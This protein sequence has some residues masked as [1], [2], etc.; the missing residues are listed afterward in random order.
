MIAKKR[1]IPLKIL[2]LTALLRRLPKNH[3]KRPQI[4]VE[5]SRRIAG[6]KGEES[7]DF[8]LNSLDEKKYMIIHD[9][10]LPDGKYNCQIDT[11]L[12]SS[13]YALIIEIKNMAGKLIFDTDNDQFIQIVNGSEK[14][15]AD[16]I[17]QAERQ[18]EYFKKLFPTLIVDYLIV[19]T[20]PH[21]ILSFIGKNTQIKQRVCKS[22]SFLKKIEVFKKIYTDEILT[23]KDLRKV[24]RT[25]IKMNTP[26]TA[27]IF[28]K[29][30]IKK[31]ELITGI[32]CP[33][34]SFLPLVRE[35]R[36]WFCPSCQTFSKDA[37]LY[38]LQDYF[39]LFNSKITNE[40]F[41]KFT[42]CKSSNIA[43]KLLL[44][45]DLNNSGTN[46]GRTYFPNTLPLEN[47]EK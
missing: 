20:N 45:C 44:M 24:S 16:P 8:Y 41:R 35:K 12:L 31:S 42:S 30:G 28:E 34:C 15:Y 6:F 43:Y 27:Y 22:H 23:S 14:G 37:H 10:N 11:L 33:N 13:N 9:L 5:L 2:I 38:G 21:S 1:T 36:K 29:Y 7:F 18:K 32:H 17:A 26:P 47:L 19:F 25:L 3:I 46:K 4:L 39:L 40:E